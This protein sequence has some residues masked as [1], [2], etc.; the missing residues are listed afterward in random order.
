MKKILF[1][2][3][4]AATMIGCK[5]KQIVAS[6]T[7]AKLD[8]QSREIVENHL[9]SFPKFTTLSGSVQVTYNDGK[10]EQSLPLSFRMQKDKAIWL[11]APLGIAKTYITPEKAEY[12]NRL[13]NTYFSGDYAYIS[14]LLGIDV[15]FEELQNLLLGN[16]VYRINPTDGDAKIEHLPTENNLYRL[17]VT[18]K[19]PIEATYGFL[20]DSYKIGSTLITNAAQGQKATAA[21]TYQKVGELLL[22]NT[23]KVVASDKS[24]STEIT[25]EF[26]SL[27]LNKELKFPFNIPSGLKPLQ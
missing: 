26:N 2:C 21:Y 5:S 19:S 13:D 25:L 14:K 3:L 12:Y 8:T 27:E 16:A 1:I 6:T 23:I 17:K 11:S 7:T 18:G 20:P 9:K 24:G 22:P 4:T 15:R 10:S